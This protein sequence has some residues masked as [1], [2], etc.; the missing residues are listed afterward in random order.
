MPVLVDIP[1]R[2]FTGIWDEWK[3]FHV[4]RD[5]Q[6]R[7]EIYIGHVIS[8]R[9]R[10]DKTNVLTGREIHANIMSFE[11]IPPFYKVVGLS[12]YQR[13]DFKETPTTR[14]KV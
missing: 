10:N 8:F 3:T 13:L 12:V 1:K 14:R 4:I 5:I 11:P 6:N 7:H 9:E 2:S